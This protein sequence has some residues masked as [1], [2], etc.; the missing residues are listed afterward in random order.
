MKGFSTV[1]QCFGKS[2]RPDRHN[3]KFLKID[4]VAGVFSAIDDVHHRHRQPMCFFS[5]KICIKRQFFCLCR[6]PCHGHRH[7]ENSIRAQFG[8]IRRSVESLQKGIDHTLPSGVLADKF[9]GDY[10]IYVGNSFQHS[11]APVTKFIAVP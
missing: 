9:W 5:A 8:F 3:H 4:T 10:V 7:T 11:L 2:R 1:T 6:R